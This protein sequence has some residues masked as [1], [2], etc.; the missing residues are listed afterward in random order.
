M[1]AEG[2]LYDLA[3]AAGLKRKGRLSKLRDQGRS[4]H[5]SEIAPTL[6]GP[7]FVGVLPSK[8][9]KIL[10][11]PRALQCLLGASSRLLPSALLIGGGAASASKL[12][13]QVTE[14][15]LFFSWFG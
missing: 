13:E 2:G 8:C 5:L 15:G 12:H 10:S 9:G 1:E 7:G 6:C 3:D 14:L 11:G 4:R